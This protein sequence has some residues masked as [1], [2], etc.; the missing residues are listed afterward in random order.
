MIQIDNLHS[1]YGEIEA[2]KGISLTIR[3]HAITCLIGNN[4]A[5]KSTL[6]KSISGLIKYTGTIVLDG[7]IHLEN[8]PPSKIARYGVIHVPEG[9][10][11]FPGL[12][13][14]QN[15]ET[16]TIGWHGMLGR[17]P[18]NKEMEEVFEMFPRLKERRNQY[19][20]SLSGGEQQML[21][22]GRALM[23][24][25]KVL[26]LDEPSMGLAPV[27]VA[28]VFKKIIQINR[29]YKTTILL[30][31]QN[32]RSTMKISDYCYVMETGKI[33]LSGDSKELINDDRVRKA[34]FGGLGASQ[35]AD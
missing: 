32:A 28:E 18:Y 13:V 8:L 35:K 7:K 24:R 34:Y 15:L 2:I 10:Q 30:V 14:E 20:W 17:K 27:L 31:E 12:T 19:G 16:G 21:A 22:V 29:E 25:P 33:V 4:G 23:A 3:E 11:V 5:G 26:M 6:L 1:Y 9:R